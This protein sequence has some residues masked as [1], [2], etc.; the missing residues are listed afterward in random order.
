MGASE[1]SILLKP[2]CVAALSLIALAVTGCA[3]GGGDAAPATPSSAGPTSAASSPSPSAL[4][5]TS[6]ATPTATPARHRR[7]RSPFAS[8]ALRR[9]LA[10]RSGSVTAA[11]FD[12]RTNH[13]WVLHPGL[14]Q[15]TASIVKVQI[16]GTALQE[17]Q[18]SGQGVPAAEKALIPAMIENSDNDAAT[19]LLREVGGPAALAKFD[20]SAGLTQTTP[21]TLQFIPGTT[22]PGWGLTKTTALD[23][24]RLVAR[25]A[26][27]SSI[28]STASRQYGLSLMEHVEADQRWG[29]TGGVP[30]DTLVALKNGWLPLGSSGWQIDSIGWIA[31]HGRDYVLA[32]LAAGNPSYDYG[33]STIETISG[34]IYRSQ[35][36]AGR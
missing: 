34:F 1:W 24:V 22:L 10:G 15:Y 8:P 26:Y 25:F 18:A 20:H 21:S 35:G 32:V 27:P 11:L 33:I 14:R 7:A 3:H 23:Q 12:A 5:T 19:T 2:R 30:P 13:V 9:Y 16:L 29:V 6:S 4:A 28:L 17:G 31:G 36:H